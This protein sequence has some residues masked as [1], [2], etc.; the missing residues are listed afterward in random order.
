M[1][2]NKKHP[3]YMKKD[4]QEDKTVKLLVL[5]FE[6]NCLFAF[7]H[8]A[9]NQNFKNMTHRTLHFLKFPVFK[10]KYLRTCL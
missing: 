4:D 3:V 1:A 10:N 2:G 5:V 9:T 6:R 8:Y 7:L